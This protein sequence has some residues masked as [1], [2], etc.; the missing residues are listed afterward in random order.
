[1]EGEKETVARLACLD[2]L[3]MEAKEEELPEDEN[4]RQMKPETQEAIMKIMAEENK[5]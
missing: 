1:M 5:N 4:G 3:N 2:V